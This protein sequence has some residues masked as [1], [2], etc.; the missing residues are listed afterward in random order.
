MASKQKK[1]MHRIV[2]KLKE[3]EIEKTDFINWSL[4]DLRIVSKLGEQHKEI[5]AKYK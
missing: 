2:I 5:V 4:E 1:V 3:E